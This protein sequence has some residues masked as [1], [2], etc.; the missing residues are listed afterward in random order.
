MSEKLKTEHF[1]LVLS[2]LF[3]QMDATLMIKV[4]EAGE[5]GDKQGDLKRHIHEEKS[6][7]GASEGGSKR[8][9][10]E[11]REREY[12]EK[13]CGEINKDVSE[14][15]DVIRW[16]EDVMLTNMAA[17]CV[18]WPT[19]H[20][21]FVELVGKA[22]HKHLPRERVSLPIRF[23]MPLPGLF[24]AILSHAHASSLG[25]GRWSFVTQD[26]VCAFLGQWEKKT[27]KRGSYGIVSPP[28]EIQFDVPK[29][30][31]VVTFHCCVYNAYGTKQW[32][33]IYNLV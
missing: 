17:I 33:L 3:N 25:H 2:S 7:E 15:T 28:L 13:R 20:R 11:V 24:G 9:K 29:D 14:W 4:E 22:L 31:A 12:L 27:F 6:E 26:E 8:A 18:G 5:E 10:L 30:S 16:K 32:P 21:Q 23:S 1:F 19:L